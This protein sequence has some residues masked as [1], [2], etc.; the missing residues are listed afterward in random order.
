MEYKIYKNYNFY[1]LLFYQYTYLPQFL[2]MH[3]FCPNVKILNI[4]HTEMYQNYKLC[5]L[6]LYV[7]IL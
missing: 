2:S 6:Y 7:S 4:I 5:R 1:Q 3:I